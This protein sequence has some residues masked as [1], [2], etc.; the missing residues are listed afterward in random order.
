MLDRELVHGP[1]LISQCDR[2][3]VSDWYPLHLR[4]RSEEICKGINS[5]YKINKKTGVIQHNERSKPTN[6]N[7]HGRVGL[8]L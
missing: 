7:K 6:P 8:C 3:T 4:H 5:R 2:E 1:S